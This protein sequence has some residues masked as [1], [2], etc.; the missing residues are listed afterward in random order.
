MNYGELLENILIDCV[1]TDCEHCV[2]NL[3]C[4]KHGIT[5]HEIKKYLIECNKR[6]LDTEKT[7]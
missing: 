3:I 2:L 1:N 5:P 6:L 7:C 4:E